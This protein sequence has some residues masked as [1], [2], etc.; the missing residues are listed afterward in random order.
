MILGW[1]I[2]V[3]L[4]AHY[5]WLNARVFLAKLPEGTVP[6]GL[7]HLSA[8]QRPTIFVHGEG[9]GQKDNLVQ[10]GKE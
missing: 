9:K 8:E 1:R 6:V 4:G 5:W 10:S 2:K 3:L 7:V